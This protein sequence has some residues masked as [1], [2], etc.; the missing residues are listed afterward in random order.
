VGYRCESVRGDSMARQERR[1]LTLA[2]HSLYLEAW[3]H[4]LMSFSWKAC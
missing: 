2:P 4:P 3:M 1:R